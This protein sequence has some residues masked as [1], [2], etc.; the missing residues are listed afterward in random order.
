MIPNYDPNTG[1]HYG[2]ISMNSINPEVASDL[3]IG[4]NTR[5]LGYEAAVEEIKKDLA[6]INAHEDLTEREQMYRR[7]LADFVFLRHIDRLVEEL[8]STSDETA[9][10]DVVEQDFNDNYQSDEI[11]WFYEADGYQLKH[12]LT[13]DAFVI[14]SPFYTYAPECS[15]CV[16][17]A[18]NLDSIRSE[19]CHE[20]SGYLKTYCLGH[21]FFDNNH[22]PYPVFSVETNE[23]I[24]P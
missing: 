4:P 11:D 16:P 23:H 1:I 6:R 21:D 22:A 8:M 24:N 18:G 2:C 14:L 12:C 5:D 10:W 7:N 17:N 3:V 19:S 20:K 9:L 13:N 15:P